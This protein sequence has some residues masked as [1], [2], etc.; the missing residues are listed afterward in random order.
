MWF[1][2]TC[3][4]CSAPR[5]LREGGHHSAS[6]CGPQQSAEGGGQVGTD[7][8]VGD[9]RVLTAQTGVISKDVGVMTDP[10]DFADC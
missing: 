4:S 10:G 6:S 3:L 8:A 2:P 1:S 9:S 5:K 7:H